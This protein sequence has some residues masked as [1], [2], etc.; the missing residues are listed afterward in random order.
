MV[1][2]KDFIYN[3]Y[4]GTHVTDC[5]TDDMVWIQSTRM[6]WLN[7]RLWFLKKEKTI[8][9]IYV[10]HICVYLICILYILYIA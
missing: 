2:K 10:L 1:Y 3:I 4:C 6:P 5:V 7:T 9:L 8:Y